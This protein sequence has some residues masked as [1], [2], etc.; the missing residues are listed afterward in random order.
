MDGGAEIF[1]M[2]DKNEPQCAVTA[3]AWR[4]THKDK[5]ENVLAATYSTNK[6]IHWLSTTGKK[7]TEL[8][9]D[10][11]LLDI[12]YFPNG[13]KF[14]VGCGNG[15]ICMYDDVKRSKFDVFDKSKAHG[16][17]V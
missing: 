14:V 8:E 13:E 9:Q 3:F 16:N 2:V 6:I 7:L 5:T 4:P 1:S 15:T 10:T 11:E 17:K 12:A